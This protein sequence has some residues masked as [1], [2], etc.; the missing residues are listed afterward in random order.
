MDLKGVEPHT[1][2]SNLSC[3]DDKNTEGC[4]S[5]S[6]LPQYKLYGKNPA[7]NKT[8][9]RE[10][11]NNK[12]QEFQNKCSLNNN[13]VQ[14]CCSADDTKLGFMADFVK[15]DVKDKKIRRDENGDYFICAE[16]SNNPDCK[17]P[18]GYDLCKLSSPEMTL[19]TL[20]NGEQKVSGATPDC[21]KGTCASTND[22][23]YLEDEQMRQFYSLQDSEI[24]TA[25]QKNNAEQI[26]DIL[27]DQARISK[28]LSVGYEGNT[29]LHHAVLYDATE[30]IMLLL[31]RKVSLD[32]KNKDG[33]T[34]LHLAALK[35]NSA[36]LHQMIEM[37]GDAEV[38]NNLGDTVLLSAIRSADYPTV[39]VVLQL[40]SATP[41][42][43][44]KLG[45]TPLH[46]ALISPQ[47]NVDIVR[48]LVNKG[49]DLYE[50]N[51]NG[52]TALKT[53]E[54]QRR[55][56]ENEEIRTY[57]MNIIIKKE[58]KNFM[59]KVKQYPE[60][61]N[62]QVVNSQGKP[63]KFKYLEGLEG[64]EI[65]LP[66]QYLPDNL[67]FTEDKQ[68]K[69]KELTDAEKMR[70][71]E[72]NPL[73]DVNY[74]DRGASDNAVE[75]VGSTIYTRGSVKSSNKLQ[76]HSHF[77]KENRAVLNSLIQEARNKPDADNSIMGK[78]KKTLKDT[79]YTPYNNSKN[80]VDNK[81]SS[82][83]NNKINN[84]VK[85]T[86]EELAALKAKVDMA[87]KKEQEKLANLESQKNK[88]LEELKKEQEKGTLAKLFGGD[89]TENI[90]FEINVINQ[91][92]TNTE[93]T[94]TNIQ[95]IQYAEGDIIT[96]SVIAGGDVTTTV[97]GEGAIVSEGDVTVQGEGAVMATDGS[98]VAINQSIDQSTIMGDVIT[99]DVNQTTIFDESTNM[100]DVI[101][102]DVN[103]T[104]TVFDES[105]NM[106]DVITT[107][108]NETTTVV[109]A[110]G[111]SNKIMEAFTLIPK[112]QN[113]FY[114]FALIVLILFLLIA[115]LSAK[116]LI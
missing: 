55:T 6:P 3:I 86:E 60:L 38:K 23:G 78:I 37:G 80:N 108:V 36:I 84:K 42:S 33:N 76:D 116:K 101:T 11:R 15:M 10:Q 93:T 100:G 48:L 65:S 2:L 63:I 109:D 27:K 52:H 67:Q 98:A 110:S 75:S 97:V 59:K 91:N 72:T 39:H 49:V 69:Y 8:F 18:S 81:V 68:L 50:R 64:V 51:N 35:G 57:L 30:I 102:T 22:L 21:F 5:F 96:D 61:A 20:D 107:N 45:E 113:R 82:K 9:T 88:L 4:N 53:L 83:T 85:K 103:E 58:G 29:M 115:I 105:T 25:I 66:D 24:L 62:F 32:A 41:I 112:K 99:T 56:K 31:A 87:K 79:G 34:P 71:N 77:S 43:R 12:L 70:G 111:S 44:N 94:L 13:K 89:N 73:N 7:T 54:F 95:N 1:I 17:V 26:K 92:I 46:I 104:T 106:G 16:N 90:Q 47:K 28:P 14:T 19:T 40:A 74:F 114:L